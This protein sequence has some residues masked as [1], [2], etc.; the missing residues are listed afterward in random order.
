M[1][2]QKGVY[3]KKSFRPDPFSEG[4]SENSFNIGAS[5]KSVSVMLKGKYT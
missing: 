5:F 2:F 1:S 4:C 3:S